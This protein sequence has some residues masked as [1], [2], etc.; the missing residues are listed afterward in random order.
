MNQKARNN[1]AHALIDGKIL[2]TKI[3]TF[4]GQLNWSKTCWIQTVRATVKHDRIN[5]KLQPTK[6][7]TFCVTGWFSRCSARQRLL[8]LQ[9]SSC[10]ARSTK[11]KFTVWALSRLVA[12]QRNILV[13]SYLNISSQRYGTTRMQLQRMLAIHP[14]CRWSNACWTRYYCPLW[15]DSVEKLLLI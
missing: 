15:A 3:L 1:C 14:P 7:A 8:L 11:I 10:C 12:V 9:H 6:H 4:M 13:H 2:S 5:S